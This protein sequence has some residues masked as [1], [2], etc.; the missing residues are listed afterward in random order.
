MRGL[1]L[2]LSLL[3]AGATSVLAGQAPGG[4]RVA[5]TLTEE[6]TGAAAALLRDGR[7]LIVGGYTPDGRGVIRSAEVWDPRTQTSKPAGQMRISRAQPSAT[8][9]ADGRVLVAGGES[10]QPGTSGTQAS[11]EIWDPAT[12]TF[13]PAAT[14]PDARRA[15]SAVRLADGRVAVFEGNRGGYFVDVWSPGA[16]AWDEIGLGNQPRFLKTQIVP[17]P[18]GGLLQV[19]AI[20]GAGA[21]FLARKWVGRQGPWVEVAKLEMTQSNHV[22]TIM[23]S[24]GRVLIV[25]LDRLL[26]WNPL[27]GQRKEAAQGTLGSEIFPC[28]PQLLIGPDRLMCLSSQGDTTRTLLVDLKTLGGGFAGEIRPKTDGPFVLLGDGRVLA[29]S[30]KKALLWTPGGWRPQRRQDDRGGRSRANSAGL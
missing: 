25:F 21:A 3:C 6:R 13:S 5:S 28:R 14:M 11:V 26:L 9:L 15:H 10:L 8:L 30:G 22:G 4:W 17:L 24:D 2:S 29:V 7:V 18:A 19:S 16:A 23:L 20:P 12:A 1:I 27:T